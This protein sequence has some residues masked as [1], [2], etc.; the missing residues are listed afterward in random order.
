MRN[1]PRSGSRNSWKRIKNVNVAKSLW[2][3]NPMNFFWVSQFL[4]Q[5]GIL[6]DYLPKGQTI[7]TQYYSSL[8]VQLRIF[9]RKNA[10]VSSPTVSC[11][12]TTMPRLAGHFQPRRNCPIWAS[13]VLITHPILRIWP[14]RTSTCSLD[15][16][17]NWKV[18]IF[19]PRRRT[20]LPRR[21]GWTNKI[22]EFFLSGLQRLEQRTKKCIEYII[23]NKLTRCNSGSIV[24]IKS[25]SM[26]YMFRTPFASIIRS[27]IN[28]NS[29][30]WCLSRCNLQSYV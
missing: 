9:W 2:S 24:L 3:D 30:H 1:S 22:S 5:D 28:C 17:S 29:S 11:S 13:N 19:R 20:L 7:N 16:K 8:L 21:A 18:A 25:R 27:T 15:W 14:L 12:Y 10:A 23:Y 4:D 26:L 6:I